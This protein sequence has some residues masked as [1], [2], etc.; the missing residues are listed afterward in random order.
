[1]ATYNSCHNQLDR[2]KYF[3]SFVIEECRN[4]AISCDRSVWQSIDM[5]SNFK[6]LY[7]RWFLLLLHFSN[8]NNLTIICSY[9]FT[10]LH[11]F[12]LIPLHSLIY[13]FLRCSW[14]KCG[15]EILPRPLRKKQNYHNFIN[16]IGIKTL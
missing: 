7:Y 4:T 13:S 8:F 10:F 16:S 12:T 15:G 1:M 14:R 11:S 6:S 2:L 9:T 3:T 5:C